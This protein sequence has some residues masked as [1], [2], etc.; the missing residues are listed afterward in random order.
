MQILQYLLYIYGNVPDF[1]QF[2]MQEVQLTMD[3]KVKDLITNLQECQN[4]LEVLC[5]QHHRSSYID[6]SDVVN[7]SP[8][9]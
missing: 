8:F 5:S 9:V 4:S 1:V 6:K 2:A 7:R 3:S